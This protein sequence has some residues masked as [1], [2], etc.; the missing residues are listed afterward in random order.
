MAKQL[1]AEERILKDAPAGGRLAQA[2][3][4]HAA[5]AKSAGTAAWAFCR[6]IM[7]EKHTGCKNC[8]SCLKFDGGNHVDVFSVE[9]EGT[10]KKEDVEDIPDFIASKAYEGGYKCVFIRDMDM[11]TP[12]AQN[13]LLKSVEEPP[14]NVVFVF[15]TANLSGVLRT[16]RSRCV[17]ILVRPR[18]RA[19]IAAAVRGRVPR[20]LEN[21]Y[22][23]YSGGSI[24]E[25]EALLSDAEFLPAREEVMGALETL[26]TYRNPSVLKLGAV[27][28]E[29]ICARTVYAV[30]ILEDAAG[31]TFG[32]DPAYTANTDMAGKLSEI[33][34]RF[35]AAGISLMIDVLLK[36]HED[37]RACPG[38]NSGL[39]AE[40]MVIKLLEVRSR[41]LR[42]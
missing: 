17:E 12:A 36:A 29:D 39:L 21:V 25:A 41:C 2:Y 40:S 31:L 10:V 22:A 4:I 30:S 33:S 38:L 34:R 7:C 27:F 18:P 13:L 28:A 8:T 26:Y 3:L 23:S 20:E 37:K 11:L 1:S 6:R 19:E 32:A 24:D 16:I 14:E 35:T 5:S 42:L 15:S 9:K